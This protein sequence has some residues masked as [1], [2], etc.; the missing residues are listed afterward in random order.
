MTKLEGGLDS[1]ASS[2]WDDFFFQ[3][4]GVANASGLVAERAYR[5]YIEGANAVTKS[6]DV[7]VGETPKELVWSL[8]KAKPYRYIPLVEPE[9]QHRT[10]LLL[11]Y[12]LI[13]KPFIFDLVPGRSFIEFMVEN[14]FDVFLL[15][16]GIPGLEDKNTTMDDYVVKY[17]YRAV[18]K[19]LRV[20][21]SKD[22]SILGYCIGATLTVAFAGAYPEVPIR[23]IVLLTAPV[24]FSHQP[25]GSMAV[26]LDEGRLDVDKLVDTVENIPGELIREWS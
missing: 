3:L 15:D 1:E 4:D 24:D 26:W 10:P 25:E 13:N 8:N 16:W 20:S 17:L 12:A 18:R 2:P 19:V 21:K 5:S 14:G 7:S 22:I 11:V 6:L 9:K 23:N